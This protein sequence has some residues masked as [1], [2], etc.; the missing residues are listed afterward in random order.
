MERKVSVIIPVYNASE[1]LVRC[2]ESIVLGEFEDVEVILVE[3]CSKDNSWDICQLLSERYQ[4]VKCYQNPKNKGV[5]YTRNQGLYHAD[6]DFVMFVDSDDWVSSKYIEKMVEAAE[7]NEE[8]LNICGF[9]YLDNVVGYRRKYLWNDGEEEI[10][11]VDSDYFF[12]LVENSLLQ[13]LCNKIFRMDIIL[14]NKICLDES[15]NMGED[16]QFVLD[17]MHASQTKKCRIINQ[18]LYYYVRE[19][20]VS[21]MSRFGLIEHDNEFNRLDKLRDICGVNKTTIDKRYEKAVEDLKY[22]YIYHIC[23][24]SKISVTEKLAF[25][26]KYMKDGKAKKH[27]Y[28]QKELIYKEKIMSY[29]TKCKDLPIRVKGKLQRIRRDNIAKKAQMQLKIKDISIISQNCIGGV[30]YHDMHMQFLSP[31]I[32][33]FFKEPDF[34]KFVRN[35]EYYMSV[36]LKMCWGEEY[37]IGILEDIKIYFM[38]Y[39]TCLEAKESWERRRQRINWNKIFILAT[40]QEGFDENV[41]RQWSQIKYPKVLFTVVERKSFD[42]VSFPQY[43]ES[44]CV[45]NL[46][47]DREFY[48][49][50]ILIK[51]INNYKTY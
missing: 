18:P 9:Y 5:S 16:F 13:S 24:S 39:K 21:L 3:D 32:D 10:C 22:N 50:G 23:R 42:I 38:H 15:Q 45:P 37:P 47:P 41:W 25:I 1:S 43:K 2:V 27:Y 20:N 17:Y 28:N 30:F 46:I 33:L 4:N 36:D 12:S 6:S 11:T 44:G 48:K 51:S 31:T 19:N 35:L 7:N 40:D 26:E 8:S 49:D 34:V 14:S 29:I